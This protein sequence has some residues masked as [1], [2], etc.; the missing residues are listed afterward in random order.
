MYVAPTPPI[1]TLFKAEPRTVVAADLPPYVRNA[2]WTGQKFPGGMSSVDL[3]YTDYWTLRA[4]SAALFRK[5]LYARGIVRRVITNE[6]NVGL[7]LEATPEERILGYQE[8][9]LSDWNEDVENRFRL[10]EKDPWLCDFQEQKTFGELQA[11][12]RLEAI[13]AGDVLVVLRQFQPTGLPRVQLISGQAVRSPWDKVPTRAGHRIEHGV[14]LDATGKHVA[15]WI[16]NVDNTFKRL[17]AWGEKS[18]R[19]LAWLLYGT[20]KRHDDVRGEPLLS[21]VL[22]SLKEIDQYRDSIQRKALVLSLLAMFVKKAVDKP[23][24]MPIAGGAVRRGLDVTQDSAGTERKYRSAEMI[25][26]FVIDELQP[27]EEPMAF[28]HQ[29]AYEKFGEFEEAIVQGV[30]WALEIPP[31]ILRLAFSNNYSASQAAINEYKMALNKARTWFGAG[32]CQPIYVEWALSAALTKKVAAPGLL[33][34]W[35]DAA[36]YDVFGAWTAAD[37]TGAIKPAVDLSRLVEGYK[38]MIAEG[39][40]TRDRASRELNGTKYAKNAQKLRRENEA[41][42][43]ALKPLGA[44]EPKSPPAPAD[45]PK[46]IDKEEEAA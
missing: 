9:D 7:H 42:A 26:G 29:G 17:P 19:R 6:I 44:A 8:D 11:Q 39:L 35:R 30:A 2:N 33:E 36:Q 24:T 41:L 3:L 38:E 31:E 23:G 5:N 37:W 20:D 34:S 27:G 22:Q 46:D 21:L 4:H 10:W 43:A 18:G 13:V 32:F 12:A 15:Y 14:E 25:P 28:Q 1:R 40:I 45:K 16:Q